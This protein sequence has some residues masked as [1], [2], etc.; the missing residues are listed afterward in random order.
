MSE[1]VPKWTV[2]YRPGPIAAEIRFAAPLAA[3]AGV[4]V[5]V[6]AGVKS[7]MESA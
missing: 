2:T 7:Q 4:V 3:G 5:D 6:G 1:T